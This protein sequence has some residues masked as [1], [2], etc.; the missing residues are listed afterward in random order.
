V[1][2]GTIRIAGLAKS[3]GATRVLDGVDLDLSPGSIMALLGVSGCGKTTMLRLIAGFEQPDA[4]TIE[5]GGRTVAGGAWVPAHRRGIGYVPQNG[6]VFPHLTVAGNVG[7]GLSRAERRTG[8][9]DR[10]LDLVG[11][12]GLA[13]RMPHHL[14]GG[15]QQR[16]ALARALAPMPALILLDEPFNA[17]DA[18][19]R[20]TLCAEVRRIIKASGASALLVTHDRDEAFSVADTVAVLQ[21][22]RVAQVGTPGALYRAPLSVET[23]RLVGLA[24]IVPA[25]LSDRAAVGALGRLPAANPQA[26]ADGPVLA[27]LRPEQIVPAAPGKGRAAVVQSVATLGPL[28]WLSLALAD[29]PPHDPP[30]TACWLQPVPPA[31]G[32]AVEIAVD[33]EALVLPPVPP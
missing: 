26:L 9:V 24:N 21:A 13:D 10:L 23:A 25:I 4:G 20:R 12:A 14:S 29:A 6:M 19:L 33:G 8:R 31:V 32:A 16:V 5:F 18:H 17:L 30:L 22:G 1:T 28:T 3:F 11:M 15:Q 27:M 2:E 7:F